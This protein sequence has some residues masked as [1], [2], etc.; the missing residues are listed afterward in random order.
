MLYIYEA[1]AIAFILTSIFGIYYLTY[2]NLI[3]NWSKLRALSGD[4]RVNS[5]INF[6]QGIRELI[7]Y[8]KFEYLK[9]EFSKNNEIFLNQMKKIN[10]LNIIPKIT[11][12][13]FFVTLILSVIIFH[14]NRNLNNENLLFSLSLFVVVL[15]R[16]MPS[17]NRMIFN[18]NQ[19]KYSNENIITLNKF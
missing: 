13:L 11:L 8:S 19:F 7:I 6:F 15:I 1:I 14:V 4:K 10:L 17:I 9:K 3:V 5:L 2:K 12:E 16:M 18:F